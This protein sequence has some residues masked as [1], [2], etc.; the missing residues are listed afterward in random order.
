MHRTHS[1][2]SLG[3]TAAQAIIT[4]LAGQQQG[5]GQGTPP[6]MHRSASG[7]LLG[8]AGAALLVTAPLPVHDRRWPYLVYCA[9]LDN[10]QKIWVSV[11]AIPFILSPSAT[12]LGVPVALVG[13]LLS[14]S[15]LQSALKASRAQ[16][17]HQPAK[18]HLRCALLLLLQGR[19]VVL[20]KNPL[21]CQ[22]AA[23]CCPCP[24]RGQ[25]CPSCRSEW[26]PH[27]SQWDCRW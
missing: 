20:P 19:E 9:S 14:H 2:E 6:V 13:M 5:K 16:M 18:Q 23:A 3:H 15:W 8:P 21:M 22:P 12:V 11:P 7:S 1:S 27:P 10:H 25:A 26:C 17:Q 4:Q 24:A